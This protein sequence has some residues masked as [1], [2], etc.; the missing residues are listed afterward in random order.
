MDLM[1]DIQDKDFKTMVLDTQRID[2]RCG[3]SQEN[4]V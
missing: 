4:E 2:G 3:E 1:S